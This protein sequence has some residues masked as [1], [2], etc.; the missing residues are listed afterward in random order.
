[1]KS[2]DGYVY[3]ISFVDDFSRYT[4]IFP[5]KFKSDTIVVFK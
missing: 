4:W 2:V 3:Y 5:L 1:M